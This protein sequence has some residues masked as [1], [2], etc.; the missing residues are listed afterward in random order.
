MI[1]SPVSIVLRYDAPWKSSAFQDRFMQ[2]ILVSPQHR[3]VLCGQPVSL[4]GASE[5][6]IPFSAGTVG[7]VEVSRGPGVPSVIDALPDRDWFRYLNALDSADRLEDVLARTACGS[8]LMS[9]LAEEADSALHVHGAG[10]AGC[11]VIAPGKR[12]GMPAVLLVSELCDPEDAYG[13]VSRAPLSFGVTRLHR[14]KNPFGNE[15]SCQEEEVALDLPNWP[16]DEDFPAFADRLRE[17]GERV[18]VRGEKLEAA[19]QDFERQ[20]QDTVPNMTPGP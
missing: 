14:R 20:V 4:D 7:T 3:G 12:H 16:D 5:D 10:G 6:V 9:V 17:L 19:V 11:W 13:K 2:P 18:L 8:P 15:I 1:T